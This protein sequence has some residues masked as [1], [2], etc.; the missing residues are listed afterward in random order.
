MK[1]VVFSVLLIAVAIFASTSAF[2]AVTGVCSS[3]HTMHDSQNGSAVATGGPNS[4]LLKEDCI[5]C[6]STGG[7]GPEVIGSAEPLNGLS[8]TAGVLAG[9]NFAWVAADDTKGH[10]V[11]GVK[12][13]DVNFPGLDIPGNAAAMAA[14]LTCA[15]TNGC[16]GDRSAGNEDPLSSLTGAHHGN[17]DLV[18]GN[19]NTA[20]DVPNSYRFLNGIKGIEDADY[21]ITV[22]A[23]G[24]GVDHNGYF[25]ST[26]TNAQTISAFCSNC[27]SDFHGAGT[28][29]GGAWIRH[30]TDLDL[31]AAGGEYTGYTTYNLAVPVA[32]TQTATL[33]AA[34]VQTAG[35]GIVNCISCHRAHGSD[36][37]DLL[38]FTYNQTAG[39]G[40]GTGCFVCHSTK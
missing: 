22:T 39:S 31:S 4:V 11:V 27:H 28:T 13:A 15:G 30:P 16:H 37:P 29:A 2:A 35:N 20:A 10:N 5:V 40:D 26:T 8:G 3:C 14:Q 38:R 23:S 24:A 33:V 34:D 32:S 36:Q 7:I 18:A 12:A 25:G 1:K 19:T 6:H 9:G 17:V 21:E